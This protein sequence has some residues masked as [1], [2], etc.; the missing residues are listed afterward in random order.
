MVKVLAIS[1]DGLL[2]L[3]MPETDE[4]FLATLPKGDLPWTMSGPVQREREKMPKRLPKDP[5]QSPEE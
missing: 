3:V 2:R 4:E 1:T 5:P